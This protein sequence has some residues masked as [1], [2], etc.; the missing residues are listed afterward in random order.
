MYEFFCVPSSL[1]EPRINMTHKIYNQNSEER[2]V[3]KFEIVF[4]M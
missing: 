1:E 4:F 2:N 3:K